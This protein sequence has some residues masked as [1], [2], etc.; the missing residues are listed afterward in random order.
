MRQLLAKLFR[1][2]DAKRLAPQER[3]RIAFE[4]T[5]KEQFLKLKE[6]GLSIQII[7]L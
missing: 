5:A 2:G 4:R 7:S 3:E 6:K 1:K